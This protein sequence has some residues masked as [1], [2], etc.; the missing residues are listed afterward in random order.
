MFIE[1]TPIKIS[2]NLSNQINQGP[3]GYNSLTLDPHKR[4][5]R[6]CLTYFVNNKTLMLAERTDYRARNSAQD[7]VSCLL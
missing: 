3:A 2:S 6:Y 5:T 1:T 4:I 7:S